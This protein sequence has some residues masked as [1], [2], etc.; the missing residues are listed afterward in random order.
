LFYPR[1]NTIHLENRDVTPTSPC[2]LQSPVTLPFYFSSSILKTEFT[3]MVSERLSI[4]LEARA[5][6]KFHSHFINKY[7]KSRIV[8]IRS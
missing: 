2:L 3:R 7:K 5:M 4:F 8:L 1:V 6:R